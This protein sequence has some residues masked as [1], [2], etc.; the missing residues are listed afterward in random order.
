MTAV[1]RRAEVLSRSCAGLLIVAS[2]AGVCVELA[3]TAVP[4]WEAIPDAW[5]PPV[6]LARIVE[7]VA[8]L[9][10]VDAD[11]VSADCAAMI[12]SLVESGCVVV[13]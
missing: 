7:H 11:V 10:D 9:F 5:S 8:E 13:G 1:L 4:V 12:V 3:G 6:P 2:T